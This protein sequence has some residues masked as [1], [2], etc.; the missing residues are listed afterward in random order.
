MINEIQTTEKRLAG[1]AIFPPEDE[2]WESAEYSKT[3]R[4]NNAG[5]AAMEAA[6]QSGHTMLYCLGFDFILEGK[7]SVQNVYKNSRNYEPHTQ[8]NTEDNYYRVKYLEWFA[9]KH[10]DIKFVFVIPDN[11]KTKKLESPNIIGLT[12]STFVDKLKD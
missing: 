3:R 8:S 4:R 6:I 10:S 7:D 12:I 2:R 9:T 5:M 1:K 11:A